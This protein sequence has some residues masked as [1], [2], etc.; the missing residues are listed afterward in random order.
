MIVCHDG[1]LVDEDRARLGLVKALYKLY[2]AGLPTSTRPTQGHHLTRVDP[3]TQ[4]LRITKE[5]DS[6]M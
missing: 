5:S 3:E 4:T 2:N 1:H 6:E